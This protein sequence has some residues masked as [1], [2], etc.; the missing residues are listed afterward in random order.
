MVQSTFTIRADATLLN[1]ALKRAPKQLT[2]EMS[3]ALDRIGFDTVAEIKRGAFGGGAQKLSVRSGALR[4]SLGHEVV[5]RGSLSRMRLVVFSAG[6]P[7]ARIQE[8]GGKI[9]PNRPGGYLTVP[10]EDDNRSGRNLRWTSAGDAIRQGAKF[11]PYDEE[12]GRKG[13]MIAFVNER[14]RDSFNRG[15]GNYIDKVAF[16]LERSVV[17]P[18]PKAPGGGRSRFGFLR[19][20][21]SQRM[22]QRRE[23]ILEKALRRAVR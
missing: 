15:E 13:W 10:D 18:G 4:E 14:G 6:V 12:G 22:R 23:R 20:W 21:N 1:R 17:I 3:G 5:N 7:Y 8:Y 19:T 16:W 2:K 11:V 9:T